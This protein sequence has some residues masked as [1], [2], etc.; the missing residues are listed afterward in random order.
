MKHSVWKHIWSLYQSPLLKEPLWE[1][2]DE[3]TRVLCDLVRILHLVP[4]QP[5]RHFRV[6]H[7]MK[8]H[9]FGTEH[10]PR[11]IPSLK[12]DM[13]VTN[14]IGIASPTWKVQGETR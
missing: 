12:L 1:R 7:K 3:L 8:L 13:I 4:Q 6:Q 10:T 2:G 14:S 9:V 11:S 5:L